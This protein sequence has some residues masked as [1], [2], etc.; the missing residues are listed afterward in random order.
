MAIGVEK[1]NGA[2][3]VVFPRNSPIPNAKILP[4]TTSYDGQTEAAIRVYQGDKEI[5]R[6]NELLGELVLS[7]LP[8]GP[9]R[10][11][12]LEVE[13][14]VSIEG[15]LH[16]SARDATTGRAVTSSIRLGPGL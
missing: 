8:P 9:A 16:A 2:M 15:I 13:F 14:D 5:A 10:S 3:H 12:K 11:A 7:G 1:A 6:D 4:V